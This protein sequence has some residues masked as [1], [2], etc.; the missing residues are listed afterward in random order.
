M[1]A[2]CIGANDKMFERNSDFQYFAFKYITQDKY[3]F[4]LGNS[5]K[6]SETLK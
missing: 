3:N 4:F 1:E 6:N 5:Y 2:I